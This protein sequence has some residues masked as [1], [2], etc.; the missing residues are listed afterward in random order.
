[1]H[2]KWSFPLGIS[3]VNVTKPQKFADLVTFIE[4]IL[5]GKLHFLCSVVWYITNHKNNELFQFFM[6]KFRKPLT[7]WTIDHCT[8]SI[9]HQKT[10]FF[11]LFRG[12]LLESNIGNKWTNTITELA[13]CFSQIIYN[14]YNKSHKTK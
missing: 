7:H 10:Y 8:L 12:L 2:K 13:T 14:V 3:S 4:E 1:M 11:W 9:P 6:M 5:D